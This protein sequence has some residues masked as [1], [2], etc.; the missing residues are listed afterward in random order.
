MPACAVCAHDCPSVGFYREGAHRR[1]G[2]QRG[3]PIELQETRQGAGWGGDSMPSHLEEA[4]GIRLGTSSVSARG[5]DR[6]CEEL[7]RARRGDTKGG[8]IS[9]FMATSRFRVGARYASWE[10]RVAERRGG[11]KQPF[12]PSCPSCRNCVLLCLGLGEERFT[13]VSIAGDRRAQKKVGHVVPRKGL[14]C[15]RWIR[16]R[17]ER[18]CRP[19][20]LGSIGPMLRPRLSVLAQAISSPAEASSRVTR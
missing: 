11:E 7:Q 16:K 13:T 15:E 20:P 10:R 9:P 12:W 1:G 18:L 14:A 8:C 6:R 2:S 4:A 5:V 19:S 3:I 17:P